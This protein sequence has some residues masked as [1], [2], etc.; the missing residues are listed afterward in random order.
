MHNLPPYLSGV[1]TLP[2]NTSATEQTRC[3]PLGGRLI[4]DDVTGERLMNSSKY[5]ILT[6]IS[7]ARLPDL[8]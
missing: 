3:F 1:A 4:M 7:V 6:D 8:T 5:H 2:A